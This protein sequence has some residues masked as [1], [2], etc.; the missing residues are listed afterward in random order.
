MKKI[1]LLV[2][3]I[4]LFFI[5]Y[6]GKAQN[7]NW[8]SFSD[9][10]QQLINL[11]VGW[12]YAPSVGLGYGYRINSKIPV[13]MNASFSLPLGHNLPDDF[14]TKLGAQLKVVS[15]GNFSAT[16]KVYGLFTRYQS[17][18]TRLLSFG[19]EFAAVAG[20]YK[21]H[22]Y[23]AGECGFDKAISTQVMNSGKMKEYYPGIQ[24]GWYVPTG[25]NFFYGIQSG[26]SFKTNDVTLNLGKTITQDFKSTPLIPFYFQVGFNRRF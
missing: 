16:A 4:A 20:F 26:I 18:Y 14:K 10:H 8:K 6:L 21:K 17:D 22:W 24:D 9:S 7:V 5:P 23:V 2:T 19:S 25:G 1:S 3:A 12:D 11:N 13:V 15:I